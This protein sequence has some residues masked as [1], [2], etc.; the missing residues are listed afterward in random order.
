VEN[1]GKLILTINRR[2]KNV[3]N[4]SDQ[5]STVRKSN[6]YFFDLWNLKVCLF[7]NLEEG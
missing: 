5:I 6:N 2:V 1:K 7:G 3:K 4:I